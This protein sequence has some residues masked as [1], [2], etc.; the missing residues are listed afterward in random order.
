QQGQHV[1]IL[2]WLGDQ[3]VNTLSALLIQRGFKAGSF[4]GVV[5]VEKTTVAEVKQTLACALQKGLPSESRLAESIIEKCLEKY[6][7]Y[8]PEALL[9]QEYGLRAFNVQR[10]EEWL[11]GHL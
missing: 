4:A 7:E 2:P 1:Y 9:T 6:D 10:V 5:E 11:Q 3:T 8:L